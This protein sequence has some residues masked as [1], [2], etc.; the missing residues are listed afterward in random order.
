MCSIEITT[1]TLSVMGATL[2]NGGICPIT[3]N[4]DKILDRNSVRNI[5]SLM[6]SSGVYNYSGEFSFKVQWFSFRNN[7][8]N[9]K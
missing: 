1:E 4:Q 9:N 3:R 6:F 8:S 5:L 2:A 7:A